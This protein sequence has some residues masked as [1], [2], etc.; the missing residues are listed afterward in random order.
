MIR[1]GLVSWLVF[2]CMA[3]ESNE[4]IDVSEDFLEFRT[5]PGDVY[6]IFYTAEKG[7]KLLLTKKYNNWV[8]AEIAGNVSGWITMDEVFLQGSS[9][10]VSISEVIGLRKVAI[11]YG[12][13]EGSGEFGLSAGYRLTP[14]AGVDLE[15]RRLVTA[16][17]GNTLIVPKIDW[18]LYSSAGV[19][20]FVELGAGM[21]ASHT[22][23]LLVKAN[24]GLSPLMT[25]SAGV[26]FRAARSFFANI[27][28]GRTAVLGENSV[29]QFWD[30]RL[31]LE[32]VF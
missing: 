7:E 28:V 21:L 14:R 25:F 30:V 29:N 6:P 5:G 11:S 16:Y 31:E 15:L 27:L 12:W 3:A 2:F 23:K 4:W 17:S 9:P 24:N 1:W 22:E 18:Q 32:S 19:N 20:P 8:L 26:R 13:F 10:I